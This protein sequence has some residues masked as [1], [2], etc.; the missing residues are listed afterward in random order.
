[1]LLLSPGARRALTNLWYGPPPIYHYV[2]H[3][4]GALD[5]AREI[6]F[7]LAYLVYQFPGLALV[8]GLAG[9]HGLLRKDRRAA[10]ALLLVTLYAAAPS[11]LDRLDLVRARHL[12]YRHEARFFLTP[13][14]RGDD[15]ARRYGEDVFRVARPGSAI[16]ADFTPMAV[17]WYLRV[18]EGRRPD[19]G[20]VMSDPYNRPIDLA[21]LVAHEVALRPVY[22]AGSGRG[23]Y[24]LVGVTPPC[25]LEPRGP[26]FE[27]VPPARPME[28]ETDHAR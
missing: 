7:Y 20:L 12:P 11:L 2:V 21:A 8:L 10:V 18:V 14:K 9:L 19:L 4:P 26:L 15:S 6:G 13:S 16:V 25:R 24:N 1:M 5:L 3:W 17:L 28:S 23:Y 27:V 22:L